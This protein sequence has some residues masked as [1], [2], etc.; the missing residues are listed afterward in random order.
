[1]GLR[2]CRASKKSSKL[3]WLSTFSRTA[4]LA[5]ATAMLDFRSLVTSI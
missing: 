4:S 5:A 3:K 1:M 2:R